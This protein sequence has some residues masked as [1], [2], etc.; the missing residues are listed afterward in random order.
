VPDGISSSV[1]IG[2]TETFGVVAAGRRSVGFA[3]TE[4]FIMEVSS[5]VH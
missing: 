1:E 2:N 3:K 4:V 5:V